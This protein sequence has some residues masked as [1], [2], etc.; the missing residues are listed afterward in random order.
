M[1]EYKNTY[2][3]ECGSIVGID[4]KWSYGFHEGTTGRIF[5]VGEIPENHCPMCFRPRPKNNENKK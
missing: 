5:K 4:T 1:S 3:C 2:K